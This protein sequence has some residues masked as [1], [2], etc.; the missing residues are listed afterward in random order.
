MPMPVSLISMSSI[1]TLHK[2]REKLERIG[3][4]RDLTGYTPLNRTASFFRDEH[5]GLHGDSRDSTH[6][7]EQGGKACSEV[8]KHVPVPGRAVA[9]RTK[10]SR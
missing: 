1:N 6:C 4:T 10:K 3:S 2:L 5:G 7:P 9:Y 8:G